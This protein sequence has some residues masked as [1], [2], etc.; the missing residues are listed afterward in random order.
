LVLGAAISGRKAQ[1]TG[2]SPAARE[3]LAHIAQDHGV[4]ALLY[5][6]VRGGSVAGLVGKEGGMLR[7]AARENAV[8]DL[9]LNEA[10]RKT[11]NLLASAG[12]P[13][14]LLKGTPVA[15]LY[16]EEAHLR[17][18]CDTDILIPHT[19]VPAAAEALSVNGYHVSGFHQR[20]YASKQFGACRTDGSEWGVFDIHWRLSNRLLFS[21]TLR[22]AEC[23]AKRRPLPELGSNACTLSPAHLLLH[24]CI[25]R[26]A[27]GRN[28]ERNRLLWLYDIHVITRAFRAEDFEELQDLAIE[29]R[30]GRL[31]QDALIMCQYYFG[32]T[33]PEGYIAPLARNR[34]REPSA[35]LLQASKPRWAI[36]DVFALKTMRARLSF[37]GE[38]LRPSGEVQAVSL[39]PRIRR[40]TM[41]L[42]ARV[43]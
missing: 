10:T 11:L 2:W 41:H 26:I 13:A 30:V 18:R 23:W 37:A 42:L 19:A 25:H 21:D 35:H 24:A 38:L 27:H 3:R 31:C 17:T 4:A 14:L 1:L 28:T 6:R 36:A 16:Y 5:H 9:L 7:T 12:I 32:T 43:T 15:H 22:F 29:K 39:V 20:P 34:R 8:K 33:Y 40:W